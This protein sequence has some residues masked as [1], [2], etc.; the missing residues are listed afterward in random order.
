MLRLDIAT[1]LLSWAS[2]GWFFLWVTTRRREVGLGYGWLLRGLFLI[3]AV[4]VIG[5]GNTLSGNGVDVLPIGSD[6]RFDASESGVPGENA[7]VWIS[8]VTVLAFI[9]TGIAA[10]IVSVTRR[11]AGVAG[12]RADAERRSVRVAGMTGRDEYQSRFQCHSQGVPACVGPCGGCNGH[13]RCCVSRS[14]R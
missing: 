9:G 10:A 8:H 4:G 6:M 7:S 1:I 2:G 11:R 14:R 5:I 3:L 13:I 12:Q